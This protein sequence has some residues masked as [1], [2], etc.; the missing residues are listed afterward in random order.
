M[1]KVN[2]TLPIQTVWDSGKPNSHSSGIS[3]IVGDRV[4]R[5]RE[6]GSVWGSTGGGNGGWL[7][8][9]QCHVWL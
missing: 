1:V 4:R 8:V 7:E 5:E 3:Q 2:I 9:K 6:R